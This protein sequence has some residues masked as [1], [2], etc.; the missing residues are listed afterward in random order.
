MF[1][2]G[3][4]LD[5]ACPIKSKQ[6]ESKKEIEINVNNQHL[7]CTQKC[8]ISPPTQKKTD[9]NSIQPH[10]QTTNNTQNQRS[11]AEYTLVSE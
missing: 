2:H 1:E 10:K 4:Y 3:L 11:K 9:H 7:T 5:Y 8:Y 6:T